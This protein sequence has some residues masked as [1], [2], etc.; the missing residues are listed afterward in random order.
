[1]HVRVHVHAQ[2]MSTGRRA[3]MYLPKAM[4]KLAASY[5]QPLRLRRR[6]PWQTLP[7]GLQRVFID[8]STRPCM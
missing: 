7:V 2:C 3:Y 1:V 5:H 8:L 6:S 4:S